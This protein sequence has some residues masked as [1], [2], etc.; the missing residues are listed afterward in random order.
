MAYDEHLAGR[1]RAIL[2]DRH[3]LS[4]RK[5]FGG[6]AF[7]LGGHLA[8]A[9]DSRFGL[10]VRCDPD[11]TPELCDAPG[12]DA[13]EMR[14]RTMRGWIHVA[15]EQLV[16]DLELAAWVDVGAEYAAGLPPKS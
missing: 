16:D 4:E 1:I 6:L 13:V 12:V 11:A 15:P 3:D 5:M 7:L 9:A 10:M 14:G 8:V 2:R